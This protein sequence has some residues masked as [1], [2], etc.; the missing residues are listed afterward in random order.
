MGDND[1]FLVLWPVLAYTTDDLEEVRG[2]V[3]PGVGGM[4]WW[5]MKT[6]QTGHAT[7]GRPSK[8]DQV[9]R[10]LEA[11][12]MGEVTITGVNTG[13]LTGNTKVR[14]QSQRTQER[15]VEPLSPRTQSSG[16]AVKAYS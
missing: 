16:Q 14:S 6:I 8:E 4:K 2:P 10:R 1:S 5:I 13:A 3:E 9:T 12:L 7:A 15:W 11:T